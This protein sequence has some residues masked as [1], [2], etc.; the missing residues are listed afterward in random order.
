MK[1]CLGIVKIFPLGFFFLYL[2]ILLL[3]KLCGFGPLAN[4]ADRATAACWRSSAKF[5]GRGC[6]VVSVTDP[7]GR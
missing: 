2:M 4:Y 3:K 7:P 6:C 1:W 5:A